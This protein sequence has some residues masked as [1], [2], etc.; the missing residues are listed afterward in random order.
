MGRDWRTGWLPLIPKAEGYP[1]TWEEP[2]LPQV[3]LADGRSD[4]KGKVISPVPCWRRTTGWVRIL[5]AWPSE[6][7][8]LEEAASKEKPQTS[9]RQSMKR[10][11]A[12]GL[13]GEASVLAEVK[14]VP[15]RIL[16]VADREL[17]QRRWLRRTL[18]PLPPPAPLSQGPGCGQRPL[19]VGKDEPCG[20]LCSGSPWIKPL[21]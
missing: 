3:A 10:E 20:S 12:S 9:G 11:V 13:G 18:Q 7:P 21:S 6:I 2:R 4:P 1:G 16:L 5:W 19:V 14:Y 17:A 8:A 15:V